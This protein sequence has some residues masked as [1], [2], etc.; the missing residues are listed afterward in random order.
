VQEA[1]R[2]MADQQRALREELQRSAELFERAAIEGSMQTFA[3]QAAALERQEREWS[4]RAEARPDTAAAAAEQ[5]R[6]RQGADSLARQLDSLGQR[7]D[8]RG[9]STTQAAV[10]QSQ[11]Q[12]ASASQS[13]QQAGEAMQQGD[14]QQAQS[15]GRHAADQLQQVP[16][17]LDQAREHQAAAWRAEVLRFLGRSTQET[18][19][20]AMEEQR[21]AQETRS[22]ASGNQDA[23]GRQAAVEQGIGQV[24]QQLQQA[25]GR[26][27]LVSPRLG[28]A[29]AQARDHARQSRE[30]LEGS[31]PST[32]ESAGHADDAAQ[33][34]SAAAMQMMRASDDVGGAQSGSGFAEAMQRLAQLA[35]QQGQLNDQLAGL[36][37]MMGSGQES[38]M[39]QLRQL[40]AQQRRLAADLERLGATGVPGHPERL[41]DEAR[42]LADRI[43]AARLD[44]ATLER[45]QRLFRRMLDAGRTLQSDE[46]PQD[47]ERRSR[48]AGETAPYTMTNTMRARALRYPA[49]SWDELRALSP[50][51]RAMVLDYFRRL[52]AQPR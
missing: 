7:L 13:M 18:V 5:E 46:D 47:P 19:E 33:M 8:R 51:E 39:Q 16:Q 48:T 25:S 26:N 36:L 21:L 44:R 1:L 31:A 41:A 32:D 15:Q 9:D 30:A 29:L 38:V 14:R 23:R 6:L 45:Q 50:A 42:Q 2:R 22:G 10:E 20:L 40:A 17:N 49:P 34:L 11:H 52:N 37:P 27:A 12:V 24:M 3:Q 35:G 4:D 28:G 43:E